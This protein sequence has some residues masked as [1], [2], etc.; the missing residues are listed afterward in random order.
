[1]CGVCAQTI[2]IAHIS[3]QGAL[4]FPIRHVK[5]RPGPFPHLINVLWAVQSAKRTVPVY[6]PVFSSTSRSFNLAKFSSVQAT[7]HP[8]LR[9]LL[10][11]PYHTVAH[12]QLNGWRRWVRQPGGITTTRTMIG[13]ITTTRTMIVPRMHDQLLAQGVPRPVVLQ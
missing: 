3:L 5:C 13:G 9:R 8:D 10:P 1:M 4:L 12:F 2:A 6:V 7:S 11:Y